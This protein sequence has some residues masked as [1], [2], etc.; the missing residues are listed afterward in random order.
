MKH[1]FSEIEIGY[2]FVSAEARTMNTALLSLETGRLYFLSD[3]GDC[4]EDIPDDID[5]SELYVGIPH[6]HDLD[7][8]TTLVRQFIDETAPGLRDDVRHIFSRKGGYRRYKTLLIERGL[9]NSWYDY[10]NTQTIAALKKWCSENS[11]E[12]DVD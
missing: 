5:D 6:K 12:L 7:L 9:L 3:F 1:N 4:D 10:E 2:E 8:G 11:I